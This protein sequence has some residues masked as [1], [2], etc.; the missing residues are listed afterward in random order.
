MRHY[1]DKDR[2]VPKMPEPMFALGQPS[3]QLA[4]FLATPGCP[5]VLI[6]G[7]PGMGKFELLTQTM[8]ITHPGEQPAM[9]KCDPAGMNEPLGALAEL[10]QLSKGASITIPHAAR[11]L[12]LHLANETSRQ[13]L[14]V[15][16]GQY[17]DPASAYVLMT[18]ASMH[19][20]QLVVLSTRLDWNAEVN[21]VLLSEAPDNVIVLGPLELNQVRQRVSRLA[22]REVTVS[23]ARLVL[24]LS[25]GIPALVE[26]ITPELLRCSP[27]AETGPWAA[28]LLR[29]EPTENLRLVLGDLIG[30]MDPELSS[31][32]QRIATSP[33]QSIDVDS[34]PEPVQLARLLNSGY[35]RA[36]QGSISAT[37]DVLI[38]L[39]AERESSAK[40]LQAPAVDNN[41]PADSGSIARALDRGNYEQ[42]L[43]QQAGPNRESGAM[44]LIQAAREMV[45][46]YRPA[47]LGDEK[48]ARLLASINESFSAMNLDA[49]A[50][51]ALQLSRWSTGH[52][53]RWYPRLRST[54]YGLLALMTID[55][56][57]QAEEFLER[58]VRNAPPLWSE[59]NGAT[60]SLC[61]AVVHNSAGNFRAAHSAACEAASEF[62]GNDSLGLYP[63]AVFLA[64][65]LSSHHADEAHDHAVNADLKALAGQSLNGDVAGVAH[66]LWFQALSAAIANRRI[67]PRDETLAQLQL[68]EQQVD[69]PWK[70]TLGAVLGFMNPE[71][72]VE[73]EEVKDLYERGHRFAAYLLVNNPFA[74]P[75]PRGDIAMDP[76]VAGGL[77]QIERDLS[78]ISGLRTPEPPVAPAVLTVRERQIARLAQQGANNR[79]IADELYL[80]RRTVEGHL[81]RAFRKLD[82]DT[83]D[84]LTR[85]VLD[86]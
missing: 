40:E 54:I 14:V 37:A 76:R 43:K 80:S 19:K 65:S 55:G 70:W 69:C 16:D 35:L 34:L 66:P 50:E 73:F 18:V 56:P 61:A 6:L 13:L 11:L 78:E 51:S 4:T 48:P 79:E 32:L 53:G 5:T 25:G 12:S 47:P 36:D 8:R 46:D 20:L 57:P 39:L 21:E 3:D 45:G 33:T 62:A 23:T 44:L 38:Q 52:P 49:A 77:Q 22:Q 42:V 27:P 10:L 67:R 83:R 17:L 74:G 2:E 15:Q 1:A 24:R 59:L 68:L 28:H 29:C 85:I 58:V 81:Y 60:L 75:G 30:R 9:L 26:A 31:L 82:I 41:L 72:P 7:S 64:D 86:S 84:E 63:V 71:L